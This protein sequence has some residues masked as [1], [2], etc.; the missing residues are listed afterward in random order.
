MQLAVGTVSDRPW[1]AT[2]A[3]I[4]RRQ[5]T[6]RLTVCHGDDRVVITLSRGMIVRTTST[7]AADVDHCQHAARTFAFDR[8]TFELD[9][10]P[11]VVVQP[12]VD[13]RAMIYFGARYVITEIGRAS[14]R[15]RVSKQV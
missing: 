10:E 4:W 9:D 1:G 12:G 8:A 14:C 5:V 13:I 2:L 11:P 15:E 3:A 7:I 6:G